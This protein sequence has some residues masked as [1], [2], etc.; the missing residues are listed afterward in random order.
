MAR[1]ACHSNPSLRLVP[2]PLR[3]LTHPSCRLLI[4]Q[5]AG[6]VAGALAPWGAPT[7]LPARL[8]TC[9]PTHAPTA[10][11]AQIKGTLFIAH[12]PA[13]HL[14][15][16]TL[17]LSLPCTRSPR[18]LA[19]RRQH[20]AGRLLELA[21]RAHRAHGR[22]QEGLQGARR[23]RDGRSGWRQPV[24]DEGGLLAGGARA[25]ARDR[26]H[27]AHLLGI[28]RRRLQRALKLSNRT[29]APASHV[30]AF[31]VRSS[32]RSKQRQRRC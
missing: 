12:L 19:H 29:P 11:R 18:P 25:R 27:G 6:R 1:S 13:P 15:A 28:D 9:Y 32:S 7:H 16:P 20:L 23:V 14:P 4:G 30:V 31:R 24:G 22:G 21:R 5:G 2:C 8:P 3:T 26:P 17:S 10:L